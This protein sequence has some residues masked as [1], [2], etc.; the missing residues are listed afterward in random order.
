[1][2]SKNE[3]YLEPIFKSSIPKLESFKGKPLLVLFFYLGCP[4]CKGRA[5]PFANKLVYEKTPI[6]LIGIHSRFEGKEYSNEELKAAKDEFYIR[7]PYYSDKNNN[8]TFRE[9]ET[10][11][12]PH[13]I[14]F[15]KE[16]EVVQ[17]I[18]G[19]DPNKALLRIDLKIKE[20]LEI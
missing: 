20:L 19:S 9:F 17:S 11:G 15:N 13:W 10:G 16:G 12:T 14:L 6:N 8:D 18:F 7:F 4:G 3:F 2:I 1:M 5:I